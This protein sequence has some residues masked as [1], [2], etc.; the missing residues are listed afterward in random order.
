MKL[1]NN[2]RRSEYNIQQNQ[3]YSHYI[4]SVRPEIVRGLVEEAD[5]AILKVDSN[6]M[7]LF[8]SIDRKMGVYHLAPTPPGSATELEM[9][10]T[11][12]LKDILLKPN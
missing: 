7:S 12:N 4:L 5:Q 6:H 8:K 3:V 10:F 2:R 1:T 9:N 11:E